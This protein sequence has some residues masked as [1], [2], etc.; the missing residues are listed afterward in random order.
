[1]ESRNAAHSV[2]EPEGAARRDPPPQSLIDCPCRWWRPWLG[3]G[4]LDVGAIGRE[5]GEEGAGWPVLKLGLFPG[6]HLAEIELQQLRHCVGAC[7]CIRE[8]RP[9][10]GVCCS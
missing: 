8:V 9:Y 4:D 5:P 6:L 10:L 2:A 7:N 1:M 3:G